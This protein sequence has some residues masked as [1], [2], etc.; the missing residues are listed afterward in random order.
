MDL[1]LACDHRIASPDAMFGNRSAALRVI[2]GREEPTA[3]A[4]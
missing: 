1:A 2:T 3:W 4:A